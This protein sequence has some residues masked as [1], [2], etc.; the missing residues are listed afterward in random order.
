MTRVTLT[1]PLDAPEIEAARAIRPDSVVPVLRLGQQP[2]SAPPTIAEL[3]AQVE[4][5]SVLVAALVKRHGV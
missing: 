4:K 3:S 1:R 5:L 2:R